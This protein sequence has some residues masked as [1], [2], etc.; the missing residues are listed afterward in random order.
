ML[1]PVLISPATVDPVSLSEAKSHLRV[2][3]DDDDILIQSLIDAAVSHIDGPEGTLGQAISAQ[4]WA[5]EYDGFLGD[6]VLPI[7]PVQSVV[8]VIH[9]GGAFED[10]RLLNDG[11][12]AFLRANGSA[13][14]GP[15]TVTFVTG[16]S[17]VPAAIKAAILLHV[18]TLYEHRETMVETVKPSR[19]YEALLAPY[20]VWRG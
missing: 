10:Y 19:A 3:F 8:S 16:Y 15:V 6:L 14:S 12:G 1:S 9:E 20:R 17:E 2:D 13:P 5:Q 18:G 4:T 11:R 7:G